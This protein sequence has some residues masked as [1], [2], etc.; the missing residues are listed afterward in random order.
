MII[1]RTAA[2]LTTLALSIGIPLALWHLGSLEAFVNLEPREWL[3][4]PLTSGALQALLTTFGWLAWAAIA[5]SF[6]GELVERVS[7]GRWQ[8]RIP[9]ARWCRPLAVF[10]LATVMGASSISGAVVEATAGFSPNVAV[11]G[12]VSSSSENGVV[13][14]SDATGSENVLNPADDA[15][16]PA[17][18]YVVQ[19]GDDLW[20]L[21][22]LQLGEGA[23]W[24]EIADLNPTLAADPLRDLMPGTVLLLPKTQS[25]IAVTSSETYEMQQSTKTDEGLS[26]SAPVLAETETGIDSSAVAS[27][28]GSISVGAAAVLATTLA[29]RRRRR[30]EQRPVG[31]ALAKL[32]PELARVEQALDLRGALPQPPIQQDTNTVF[33]VLGTG[34]PDQVVEFDLGG[35]GVVAIIGEPTLAIGMLTA[36]A[37]QFMRDALPIADVTIVSDHADW[38]RDLDD[39][40]FTVV[41][42]STQ[43]MHNLHALLH[44]RL[45]TAMPESWVPAVFLF[46]DTPTEP[47]P[48]GLEVA[49]VSVVVAAEIAASHVITINDEQSA[50]LTTGDEVVRFVPNLATTKLRSSLQA[51][52]AQVNRSE[53]TSADWWDTAAAVVEKSTFV[54]GDGIAESVTP[55]AEITLNGNSTKLKLTIVETSSHSNTPIT[56][57]KDVVTHNLVSPQ[58]AVTTDSSRSE[59]FALRLNEPDDVTEIAFLEKDMFYDCPRLLLLGSAVLVGAKGEVPLRAVKQCTEYC[60]WIMRNPGSTSAQMA[61]DLLV[62]E[63]TRRS[64]MSR[65]RTWL[66]TTKEGALYL[67]D[68]YSGHIELH[69]QISSDWEQFRLLVAGG[70]NRAS[71]GALRMA[72]SLVRGTPLAD[73]IPGSWRWAEQWRVEMVSQIRDVAAE[74]ADRAIE[75][76]DFT[77]ARW[78]VLQGVLAA[79]ESDE[80][81]FIRR[82]RI[83]QACGNR[84]ELNQ[85][86]LQATRRARQL[87]EDLPD[88]VIMLLQEVVEM[89]IA[90]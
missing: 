9:G 49:G 65:L 55:D 37:T 21:A 27:I 11:N 51:I 83:E 46:E 71:D 1:K 40:R 61:H 35:A 80:A 54:A 56:D 15:L 69:M 31:K 74:F 50:V 57:G 53:Y 22:L 78:A 28:V 81:L 67:P 25:E 14:I 88:N 41:S 12:G 85:L 60:A 19:V 62:A 44:S 52:A 70:V 79:G 4:R 17:G 89:E 16:L 43:A 64:N 24:H 5:V 48:N 29:A 26:Q 32:E 82:M 72:L 58:D 10:L 36:V 2:L 23:R 76:R 84:Q 87:G 34:A 18:G 86:V 39:S 30:L 13:V 20:T 66:G 7:N 38:L 42:D 3:L 77:L 68:A 6:F 63:S 59:V 47:I 73:A 45:K 8:V 75:R 33:V 90:A